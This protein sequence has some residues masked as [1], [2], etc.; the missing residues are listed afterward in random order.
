MMGKSLRKLTSDILRRFRQNRNNA[1][2]D[3]L[4]FYFSGVSDGQW[5]IVR[6]YTVN[7]LFYLIAGCIFC[8]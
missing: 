7:I 4:Y 3:H 8:L 6:F 2:A 1:P 5:D